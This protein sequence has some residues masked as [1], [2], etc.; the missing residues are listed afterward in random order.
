MVA[1]TI[2][3]IKETR[4]HAIQQV[5]PAVHPWGTTLH[6]YLTAQLKSL[7]LFASYVG[8]HPRGK[9]AQ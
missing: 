9:A 8:L 7:C 2:P 5:H 4:R 3:V 1:G 6:G